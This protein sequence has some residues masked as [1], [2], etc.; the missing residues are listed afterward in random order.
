MYCVPPLTRTVPLNYILL[1]TF[2]ICEALLV[3]Y[4]CVKVNNPRAVLTAAVM[5]A[6]IVLALT[7]YAVTT[8]RDY[9]TMGAL[10]FVF[11][12]IF[13]MVGLF[14][15]MFGPKLYMIYCALGVLLFGFYLV[16]D[17]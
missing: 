6:G 3:A 5:T 11:G 13:I 15:W 9:T 17:T 10:A 16:F 14:S 12:A 1:T 8:T 2:T 7:I 4:L